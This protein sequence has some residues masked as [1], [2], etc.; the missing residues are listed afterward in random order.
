MDQIAKYFYEFGPF[1]LDPKE[2]LL[3][4]D[5]LHV[6]LTPKAFETLLVLVEN[7]GRVIDKDCLRRY[8]LIH[9]SKKSILP[10]TF[11]FCG[12][13]SV[14]SMQINISRLFQDEVIVL[15][16]ESRKFRMRTPP[17]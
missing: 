9:S 14:V 8:G 16:P 3:F 5:G 12:R 4:R 15:S 10:K 7:G 11:L 17:R 2:H 6:P 1:L 13:L